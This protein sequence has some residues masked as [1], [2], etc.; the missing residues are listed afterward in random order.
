[1]AVKQMSDINTVHNQRGYKCYE[2]FI[3]TYNNS[4]YIYTYTIIYLILF[5]N[6]C[7]I[8]LVVER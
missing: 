1:M 8:C 3:L 4:K 6:E 7:K 2:R 5:T